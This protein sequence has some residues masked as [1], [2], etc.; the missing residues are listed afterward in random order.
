[1]HPALSVI[2]FTVSSGV[3]FGMLAL[4]GIAAALQPQEAPAAAVIAEFALAFALTAFGLLSSTF[5][6]GRPERAWRAFSQWRSSWLSREGVLSV[7][8]FPAALLLAAASLGLVPQDWIRPAA[9][10]TTLL[11][12]ATLVSTGMIYA[13]LRAIP[14]WS[15]P[16]TV[17]GYLALG[18]MSGALMLHAFSGIYDIV[19]GLEPASRAAGWL[20]LALL[21]LALAVKLGYWW[22][23]DHAAPRATIESATALAGR[24]PVRQFEPPHTAENY[25]MQEMGYRI[26]RK[27]A[28]KLRRIALALGFAFPALL[29]LG[30]VLTP[31]AIGAAAL[32]LMAVLAMLTGLLIERWLFFAEARHVVTLYY[33]SAAV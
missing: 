9:I 28:K 27:H 23:I 16:W 21:V 25:V 30:S 14:R 29:I 19:A 18:L 3:G 13:S 33:G 32:S 5:H 7:A 26:A 2:L 1:M 11:S 17:P 12:V 4:L 15:N 24:G 8:T 22:S 31:G 20:P 10:A 6:L